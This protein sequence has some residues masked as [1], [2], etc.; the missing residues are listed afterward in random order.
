MGHGR[1]GLAPE[2]LATVVMRGFLEGMLRRIAVGGDGP[3]MVTETPAGG[4]REFGD[5]L[6]AIYPTAEG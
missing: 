2:Q 1:I 6:S 5:P 3:G 4:R